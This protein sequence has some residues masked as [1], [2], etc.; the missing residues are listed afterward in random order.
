MSRLPWETVAGLFGWTLFKIQ[1]SRKVDVKNPLPCT[2]RIGPRYVEVT[3]SVAGAIRSALA[4]H[5]YTINVPGPKPTGAFRLDCFQFVD[6]AKWRC[7]ESLALA[8]RMRYSYRHVG[9]SHGQ[10][11]SGPGLLGIDKSVAGAVRSALASHRRT[12]NRASLKLGAAN[13]LYSLQ[14]L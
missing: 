3:K 12:I 4:S 8:S 7:G 1:M 6:I 14:F 11:G 2:G 5:R 10:V 9:Y 13:S